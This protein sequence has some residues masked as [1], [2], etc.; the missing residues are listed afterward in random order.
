MK[1]LVGKC[2]AG[3]FALDEDGKVLD[4]I[5]FGKSPEGIA[6]KLS[7]RCDEEDRLEE[8][9]KASGYAVQQAEISDFRRIALEAG[10]VKSN[11]EL[12]K[13]LSSVNVLLVKKKSREVKKDRI[14]M[15][16][17]GTLDELERDIN[18]FIERTREWY[19]LYNPEAV[20]QESNH[21]KL[22]KSIAEGA[23]KAEDSAGMGFTEEDL[24]QL[25]DFSR[26]LL[27][28]YTQKA[29][30]AKYLERLARE[31]MPNTSAVAGEMMAARLL[32]LSGGLEKLSRMPSSTIQ[33]LGAEKALFRHLKG[34]GKSPK[35]GIL[36]FHPY[37][38][39]APDE[40]KGKVA[41]MLAAKIT[42]AARIDFF[43]K[44]DR[45]VELK[46]GLEAQLG[47][48]LK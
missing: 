48:F 21:E 23:Q 42:M 24:K 13:I 9:M 17:I 46:R 19:G 10:W 5:L 12:N 40:L 33:L 1:A 44:T 38:Q 31:E 25:R 11:T 35:Y 2:I 20:R 7:A 29:Q 22:L 32:V 28:L 14:I 36:F 3:V 39:K 16:V 43:S 30:L 15:Q 4:K 8:K 45:S 26:P 37:I 6:E 27:E 47:S 41:R 18:I 34:G